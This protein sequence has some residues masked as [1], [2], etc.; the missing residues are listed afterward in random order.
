MEAS[1]SVFVSTDEIQ[2]SFELNRK[3][4]IITR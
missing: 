1:I 2:Y 3:M 4:T